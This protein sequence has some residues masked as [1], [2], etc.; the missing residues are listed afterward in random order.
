MYLCRME[1]GVAA[2]LHVLRDESECAHCCEQ[3]TDG[4]EHDRCTA[5]RIP[6]STEENR[7]NCSAHVRCPVKDTGCGTGDCSRT[8][9]GCE[10]PNH[11]VRAREETN[12]EQQ[13]GSC[14]LGLHEREEAQQCAGNQGVADEQGFTLAVEELVRD[15]REREVRDCVADG[16]QQRA[17]DTGL[18]V[19]AHGLLEVVGD[20]GE[21]AVSAETADHD[22]EH[23][24]DELEL[25]EQSDVGIELAFFCDHL[26]ASFFDLVR[27][28]VV[29]LVRC[30]TDILRTVFTH[31]SKDD[32]C[33]DGGDQRPGEAVLPGLAEELEGDEDAQHGNDLCKGSG[34]SRD[35]VGVCTLVLR[36]PLCQH[37]EAGGPDHGLCKAVQTPKD[38]DSGQ[39]GLEADCNVADQGEDGAGEDELLDA[40]DLGETTREQMAEAITPEQSRGNNTRFC[41]AD[42]KRFSHQRKC[43]IDV[44][45]RIVDEHIEQGK[46]IQRKFRILC[47][48]FIIRLIITIRIG[49]F[50]K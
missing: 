33:C 25:L 45:P 49:C 5:S 44:L 38:R 40:E 6:N 16:E 43:G 36:P 39:G 12:E 26:A 15:T 11:A 21:E 24:A 30:K 28:A 46:G 32:D 10:R 9:V 37:A 22:D 1:L 19:E 2:D 13:D 14:S 47:K 35:T 20:P 42:T 18:H 48:F 41:V 3:N 17:D 29:L 8:D 34:A 4:N 23:E 31:N 7:L 50:T 27:I